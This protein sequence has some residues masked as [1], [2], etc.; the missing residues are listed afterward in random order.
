LD[1]KPADAYKKILKLRYIDGKSYKWLVKHLLLQG[2]D[3][4]ESVMMLRVLNENFKR[5]RFKRAK[6]DLLIAVIF[7][8][9]PLTKLLLFLF[10]LLKIKFGMVEICLYLLLS[11]FFFRIVELYQINI[12]L[13]T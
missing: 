7:I 13:D 6:T 3:K 5:K 9:I 10:G 8:T 12:S 2:F 4:N 11:L 1:S